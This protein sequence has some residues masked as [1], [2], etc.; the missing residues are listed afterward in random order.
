LR[1]RN[2]SLALGALVLLS[3]IPARAEGLR[4][5]GVVKD[6]T[7]AA[8][9]D[10]AVSLVSAQNS[11]VATTR[12]DAQGAF[13]LTAPAPGSYVVAADRA[14]FTSRRIAVAVQATEL[15]GVEV[16]L[17]PA[18]LSEEITVT[19]N[20]GGVSDVGAVT[21]Q[22]NVL[23][24]TDIADRTKAVIAQAAN[25]E[26][27]LHLQR[28]SP[29]MAEFFVRGLTGAKVSVFVDG[30]RYSTAAARG[31]VSTFFDLV[32]PATVTGVEVLRG[33]SSAQYG[34]DSIGGSVQFIT[35]TPR[36]ATA[37]SELHGNYALFGSSADA[38][39]GSHLTTTYSRP[40]FAV[41]GTLTGRRIN[42]TRAG[43]GTDSH[44]AV[45]RYFGIDPGF[46]LDDERLPDTAFTQY[47]GMLKALW[48]PNASSRVVAS[49]T[50]SQQDGGKRYDQLLGGDGNLI[51]DLRNLMLDRASVRYER[52]GL[53]FFDSLTVGY[54]LNSQREERVNQGGTGNPRAAVNHEY[55]RTTVHGLQASLG[56]TFTRHALTFGA[57][58]YFEHVTA[59]S[60]AYNPVNDTTAVRRG[61]V[62]DGS[63][64]Q[65]E[66]VYVQ[67]VFEAVPGKLQ[68]VGNLRWSGAQYEVKASDSPIVN[69]Q[70]L[71]PD[72][73]ESFSSVT[74]R[75]GAIL[76]VTDAF[77]ISANVARGY[78][79]PHITDLGTLGLTGSGFEVNANDVAGLNADVGST[80]DATAVS[81]GE[82]VETLD[83]ERSL[84]YEGS[85][86]YVRNGF[87]TNLTVFVNDIDGNIQKQALVLPQGAVGT[88]LGD[89]VVVRQT[90]G[91]AV[92]VPAN[93]TVPVLINANF[94]DA[95]IW[96]IE[97]LL[98]VRL[99]SDWRAG[100]IF[101][102]LHAEDD[103]TNL[104]PNIEGGT[105]APDG[106]IKLRWEPS[107]G[108]YWV[109]PYVHFAFEQ[110]RLSSLDLGDRRTGA[111]RS[112]TSI[113]AFFNN[114]ARARGLIGNGP[115]GAANTADDVL[116]ETGE[117]LAQIQ[118]RVLGT[119]NSSSLFTALPAYATFNVRGGYRLSPGHEI[120]ADFENLGDKNY[121]G[122]SWGIDA[123]GRSFTIRYVGQF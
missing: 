71:W 112:R 93:A 17:E 51:A 56:K 96:G 100:G 42:T 47:G 1:I 98:N 65:S 82:P 85:L 3:A 88:T 68:L 40:T 110:D 45:S 34:S 20:P 61:R 22:V 84:T 72:D 86:R 62:P 75:V 111:A 76:N 21:Q 9:A 41:Q 117:T 33:P 115:D 4:I 14:G 30:Q 35:R 104:P 18:S 57:D 11:V 5:S 60:F 39:F 122:I 52:S 103:R 36:L 23:D 29:T 99:G 87:D 15:T 123:P 49:Y 37:G 59:P 66:G 64:Y 81:I 38:G 2:L 43:D 50:R 92:F 118:N 77:A 90:A 105:P 95:R 80:A 91:G 120:V 54:S 12:T 106:W 78:R 31:G 46:V 25:E 28:T 119:A 114:G 94:D 70:P 13:A 89:Q 101:T 79:A 73:D 121:R 16:R 55:E 83:P 10:A 97:Y 44:N 113:A 8:V 107:G 19:A 63:E 102:Y 24:E 7:A 108:R 116:L 53:G 6:S 67:D 74:F 27:G 32:D 48:T 69:G 109:E 58:G 26:V